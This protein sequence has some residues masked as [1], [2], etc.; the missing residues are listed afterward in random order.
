[1]FQMKKRF[2]LLGVLSAGLLLAGIHPLELWWLSWFSF[3]PLFILFLDSD[4]GRSRLALLTLFV[5][6]VVFG[7]GLYW[8]LLYQARVYF[9]VWALLAPTFTLYFL[10]LRFL[11]RALPNISLQILA[12]SFLWLALQK[13]YSLSPI[14]TIA[15]EVPF[16]GPLPFFQIAS[17]TDFSLLGGVILGANFAL[18]L[19]MKGKGSRLQP[20]FWLVIF[21]GTLTGIY[22]WGRS[23][24]KAETNGQVKF[25]L[26]QHNLPVSGKWRLEHPVYIR[27][28]YRELALE[29]AREKPDLILFPLYT[30]PE[31]A[32]R[33]PEFFLGL[34]RETKTHILVSTYVPNVPGQSLLEAGFFNAAILYSPEGKIAD[35]YKAVRSSPFRDVAEFTERKYKVLDTPFGKVG[36]LLCYEDTLPE[37]AKE[38]VQKG[39]E[40][41]IAPSNPGHFAG[42]HMPYYHLMQ[43]RLRAIES[44]RSVVRISTNGYSAVVDRLGRFVE[45]SELGREQILHANV[46]RNRGVTFYHRYRDWLSIFSWSKRS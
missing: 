25:A 18:A 28:K 23:E 38:A 19:L 43:D 31:D 33:N 20:L 24:L 13:L 45:K 1:M 2:W 37:I 10:S 9:I 21:A 29:A 35:H 36:I 11:A 42:T 34:A 17:V 6:A 5:G 3:L 4:C 8:L 22:F 46:E 7:I 40:I 27:A 39:A 41:L 16:Y 32:L 14:G 30:F 15:T 12:A 26:I 44:N